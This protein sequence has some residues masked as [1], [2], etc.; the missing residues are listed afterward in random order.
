MVKLSKRKSRIPGIGL[1]SFRSLDCIH[2]P[3]HP[4]SDIISINILIAYSYYNIAFRFYKFLQ[5]SAL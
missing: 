4:Y 1:P 5:S 2:F 3:S